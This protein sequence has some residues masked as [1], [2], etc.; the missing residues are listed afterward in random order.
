MARA[1]EL[2]LEPLTVSV[3]EAARLSGIGRSTL[4]VL[5]AS[6]RLDYARVGRSRLV[7]VPSLKRLR[8]PMRP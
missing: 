2:P 7:L 6:K 5:M 1:Q 3:R 4:Y 8:A